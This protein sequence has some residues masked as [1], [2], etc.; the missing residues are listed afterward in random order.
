MKKYGK[1]ALTLLFSASI[2]LP[3][4]PQTFL[5]MDQDEYKQAQT[6]AI[7]EE[8]G[9]VIDNQSDLGYLTYVNHKGEKVTRN[10]HKNE[11]KVERITHYEVEDLIGY[12]DEMFPNFKFDPRDT[13][14][15]HV[16]PGDYI[17]M[18]LAPDKTITH[19]ST[20]I[21]HIVRYGKVKQFV[22]GGMGMTTMVIE[23]EQGQTF[24]MEVDSQ[25]PVMKAGIPMTVSQIQEGDW[26]KVLLSQGAI[27]PG[28]IGEYVKEII[29]D[30]GSRHISNIYRGQITHIDS[31]QSK[32]YLQ[33]T[34]PM[35]KNGWGPYKDIK[36][37]AIKQGSVQSY[38][39]GSI[40]SWDYVTRYLKNQQGY[41][42]IAMEDY[43]GSERAV[44]LD[45]QSLHQRTLPA[46]T[47]IS[48]QP[49][50]IKLMSGE[51]IEVKEDTIIRRNGR[52]VDPYS[53]M[54]SDY[55]QVVVTGE[56]K[57]A[58]IDIMDRP[59]VGNLQIFRGRIKKIQDQETFEVE[60]FSMLEGTLWMFHPIPR[61]F[62]IDNRTKFYDESG[63]ID[64]GIE[65]FIGY[66][67]GSEIEAVYTAIV[68]GDYAQ[69]VIKMPYTRHSVRGEIYESSESEIKIK[70]TYIYHEQLKRWEVKGRKDNTQNITLAPNV[71]VMKSGKII[72]PKSLVKGDRVRIMTDIDPLIDKEAG[73]EGYLII[74]EE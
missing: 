16:R 14:A 12:I 68:E 64:N 24:H 15:E 4:Y 73:V 11:V 34:Q 6:Q 40:V 60:T 50:L 63:I 59:I 8:R 28:D 42:Y 51:E 41:V 2:V 45:F 65:T 71:A 47:I 38:Y 18:H 61:T 17:Y 35:V 1:V 70:D 56:T 33:N 43:Y 39:M 9:L 54:A 25:V 44:K 57:A 58:V 21:N 55:A 36:E 66:G 67:E 37:L 3:I 22:P 53:I 49:G 26:V 29:V 48:A 13:T 10:Y 5:N 74:V 20:S 19:I 23:D 69:A 46:T 31:Y 72:S 27:A 7:K 62:T 52:L 32:I 30:R